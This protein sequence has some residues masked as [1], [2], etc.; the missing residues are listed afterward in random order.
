MYF[1]VP[2]SID[3]TYPLAQIQE[4]M[5]SRGLE[6]VGWYHSHPISLPNPSHNDILSQRTYQYKLMTSGGEEPCVGMIVG[7]DI[8]CLC[9]C[10][11]CED[12]MD[13]NFVRIV[14][15]LEMCYDLNNAL[16]ALLSNSIFF[17]P[18]NAFKLLV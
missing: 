10:D 1:F 2:K 6:L 9:V 18:S 17:Q 14:Y 15:L 3:F 8:V 16:F 7:K 5:L 11:Y 12:C 13:W 4:V